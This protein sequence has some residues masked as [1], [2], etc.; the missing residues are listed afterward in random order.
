MST[1]TTSTVATVGRRFNV[2]GMTCSHCELA[3]E[4]EVGT[5]A[6]VCRVVAD[7]SAGS[8][9]VESTHELD[10]T[11]V[12]AAVTEAGYELVR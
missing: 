3:V 12:A 2:T 5:I 9:I 6:G 4:A 11:V 7:A 10:V 8:L 1:T